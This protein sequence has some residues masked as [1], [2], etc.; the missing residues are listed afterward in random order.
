[1]V[2]QA[3]LGNLE[4]YAQRP[5]R[6]RSHTFGLKLSPGTSYDLYLRV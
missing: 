1:M 3:T 4:A 6:S 5:V 2:D